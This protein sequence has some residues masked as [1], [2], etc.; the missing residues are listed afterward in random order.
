MLGM[1]VTSSSRDFVK[2]DHDEE[3]GRVMISTQGDRAEEYA[4]Y[5]LLPL[6][7]FVGFT[8]IL[9]RSFTP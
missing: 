7:L 5:V 8:L 1:L 4:C 9:R 6:I 2:S 3:V